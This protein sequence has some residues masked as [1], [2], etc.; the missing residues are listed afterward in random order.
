MN[1]ET[2]KT[3]TTAAVNKMRAFCVCIAA[4][5]L[6][7]EK[8]NISRRIIILSAVKKKKKLFSYTLCYWQYNILSSVALGSTQTLPEMSTRNIS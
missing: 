4:R 5:Q 8:S 1:K 3:W 2:A 7:S 6:I